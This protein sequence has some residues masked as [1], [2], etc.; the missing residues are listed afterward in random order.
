[1]KNNIF[2]LLCTGMVLFFSACRETIIE[3]VPA[4]IQAD[5]EDLP[6]SVDPYKSTYQIQEYD[7]GIIIQSENGNSRKTRKRTFLCV[8]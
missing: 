1:M 3:E 4:E 5:F 8:V 6:R 2:L 7:G